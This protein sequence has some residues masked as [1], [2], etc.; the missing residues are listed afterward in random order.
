MCG[1]SA[2]CM[3]N[4]VVDPDV[5]FYCAFKLFAVTDLAVQ[6]L[7]V[8]TVIGTFTLILISG[9]LEYCKIYQQTVNIL[10]SLCTY[11]HQSFPCCIF[12]T[13]MGTANTNNLS[14]YQAGWSFCITEFQPCSPWLVIMQQQ[15][16]RSAYM[17]WLSI[18]T[19]A[20]LFKAP[21]A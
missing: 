10:L 2:E 15:R 7:G 20:Q 13:N 21:S 18:Q 9:I 1:K 17:F 6:I 4:T 11:I 12:I 8:N 14:A 5:M 3:V 16:S 19:R